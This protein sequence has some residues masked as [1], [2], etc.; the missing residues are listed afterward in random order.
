MNKISAMK[1]LREEYKFDDEKDFYG[2]DEI[3][4]QVEEKVPMPW[5]KP[6]KTDDGLPPGFVE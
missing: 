4:E 1:K 6:G 3:H 2:E 5:E